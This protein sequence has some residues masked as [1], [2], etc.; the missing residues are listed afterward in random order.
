MQT[1]SQ[2]FINN[3]L[4]T[5]EFNESTGGHQLLHRE[6]GELPEEIV[7][8]LQPHYNLLQLRREKG[9]LNDINILDF[10]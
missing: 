9:V 6:V 3:L 1:F 2:P 7:E 10:G 5:S 8:F 4:L